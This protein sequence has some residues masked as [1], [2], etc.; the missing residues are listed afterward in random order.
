MLAKQATQTVVSS[1]SIE[2]DELGGNRFSPD[3]HKC[4]ISGALCA[5]NI[6]HQ[7]L[8]DDSF[9]NGYKISIFLIERLDIY[10][11]IYIINIQIAKER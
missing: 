4:Q 1:V 7:Y 2:P 8:Y 9:H 3:P 5:R 10:G 6:R 11:I